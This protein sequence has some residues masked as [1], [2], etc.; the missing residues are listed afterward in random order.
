MDTVRDFYINYS[1]KKYNRNEVMAFH[2]K[3]GNSYKKTKAEFNISS[4][5]TLHYVLNGRHK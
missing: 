4:S 5:G 2:K 1:F 3:N